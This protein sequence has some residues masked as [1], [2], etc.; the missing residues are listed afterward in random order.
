[1]FKILLGKKPRKNTI[2][3]AAEHL[4]A[5]YGSTS[6]LEVKKYLRAIGY[7]AF[8][9]EISKK[10]DTICDENGWAFNFNGQFRVYFMPTQLTVTHNANYSIPAF[11]AN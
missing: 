10:M 5:I 2:K 9:W 4:I 7:I 6:T 8:Q 1:M 11:S 3:N